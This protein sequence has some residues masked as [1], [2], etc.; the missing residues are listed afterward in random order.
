MLQLALSL[1]TRVLRVVDWTDAI[2]DDWNNPDEW[3]YRG[4]DLNRLPCANEHVALADN[5]AITSVCPCL[6]ALACVP[7]LACPGL[8][9]LACVPLL[10]CPC[11]RACRLT[12]Q[13][14][15]YEVALDGP[16]TIRSLTF[17]Q[18]SQLITFDSVGAA[19]VF[20]SPED[21]AQLVP[22]TLPIITTTT[23][24]TTTT[25]ATTTTP[26]TTTPATTTPGTSTL[27]V[28]Y[29]FSGS[30]SAANSGKTTYTS[31]SSLA[32]PQSHT[33]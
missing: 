3:S 23:T 25:V 29:A 10:A 6:C 4:T 28:T 17:G 12:L 11:L 26:A 14:L 16:H 33:S 8:R 18:G 19:L 9:A 15:Q 21:A 30:A 20:A 1:F 27:T 13:P 24:T 32:W 5:T 22:C 7:W 2:S 31:A